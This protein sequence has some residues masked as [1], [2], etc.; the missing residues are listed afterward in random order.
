MRGR[1][2]HISEPRTRLRLHVMMSAL[3]CMILLP[4]GRAAAQAVPAGTAP[5]GDTSPYDQPL[6][7]QS[8]GS[9]LTL[10][11]GATA[12]EA[13]NESFNRY[14]LGLQV[15]GGAQTNFLG[16]QTNQVTAAY[17]S[18]TAD[19]GLNLHTQRT[20]YFLL[21]QPQYN[22]YPQFS[23]INNFAQTFYQTLDHAVT[24]HVGVSWD[25]TAARYLSLDQYLPQ[26]LGI[27]G[28]GI[29]VPT[30]QTELLQNSFE[31][32]NAATVMKLQYLISERMT[33]TGALTGGYFIMIPADRSATTPTTI[34]TERFVTAGAD[35]K[36][37]YQWTAKDSVG[38]ELTPIYIYGVKPS[39]NLKAEALQ[40]IYTRQL[41]ATTSVSVGAGPLF[42]QAS[43]PSFGSTNEVSYALTAGVSRKIRQSQQSASYSRA[44]LVGFLS[45]AIV[46]N[47]FSANS[48]VPL[49]H[50]WLATGAFNYT[51]EATSGSFGTQAGDQYGGS[52]YGGTARI[53]YL[54]GKRAEVY[55]LYARF[56]QDLSYGQTQ[57]AYNFTQNKF[58]GGIRF[59]LGN[60]NTNGGQQ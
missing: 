49:P 32:T 57:S 42:F 38:G 35:L 19:A 46:A 39:G 26:S 50:H 4:V 18:F 9:D 51:S 34:P 24:E 30:L 28:I 12:I 2:S 43:I 60:P 22:V 6:I 58:G 14:A 53:A 17:T 11:Q 54:I 48:Q 31:V 5:G 7:G 55:G 13:E 45:P 15:E 27:G 21:Y 52:L 29:V 3:V 23:S 40:A 37:T 36:L 44:F 16:S 59:N 8:L 41:N 47:E 25:L 10:N 33:F 20:Q 1:L 56:S